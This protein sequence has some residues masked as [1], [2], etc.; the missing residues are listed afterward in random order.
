M[1]RLLWTLKQHVGPAPRA[2]HAMVFDSHRSR[3]VLF[4]GDS[5]QAGRF[6]DTWE[7]DGEN[8]TQLDDIGPGARSHAAMAYDALRGSTVLFGGTNG[9]NALG[10]TWEWN[11]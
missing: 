4:G 8:W 1:A 11:G 2:A 5:L 10:D 6:G 9:A 3:A 7:W